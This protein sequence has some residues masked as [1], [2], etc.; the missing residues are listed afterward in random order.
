MCERTMQP[1][2]AICH[3]AHSTPA[4]IP[5]GCADS[6]G[7]FLITW[8]QEMPTGHRCEALDTVDMC[9]VKGIPGPQT[10]TCQ[11]L[12]RASQ[13]HR[14]SVQRTVFPRSGGNP[15]LAPIRLVSYS[16]GFRQTRGPLLP[17]NQV[18]ELQK[19]RVSLLTT[20]PFHMEW[21][22]HLQL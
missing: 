22:N 10:L 21:Q 15:S 5:L 14:V 6:P 2:E 1:P 4:G 9:C 3:L 16:G 20:Q 8:Q 19:D 13:S 7:G 12:P 18:K 11:R 17:N